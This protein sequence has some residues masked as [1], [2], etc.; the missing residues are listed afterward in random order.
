MTTYNYD[1]TNA[2]KAYEYMKYKR[3]SV[4]LGNHSLFKS[5]GLGCGTIGAI[6]ARPF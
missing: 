5:L 2:E 3:A 6:Y 1:R 4:L